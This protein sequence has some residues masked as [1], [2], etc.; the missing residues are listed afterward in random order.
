MWFI[1]YK[2]QLLIQEKQGSYHI[3]LL[4]IVEQDKLPLINQF[5]L[6]Q[7]DSIHCF[8]AEINPKTSTPSGYQSLGLRQLFGLISDDL[9]TLAGR[10]IHLLYWDSTTQFCGRC[11]HTTL[12]KTDERAKE[13]PQ[14]G[15]INYPQ[16]APAVIILIEKD[17]EILLA[18]SPR[19][20]PKMYSVI[21]GFVE[22]GETLEQTVLREIREEVGIQ[23]HNI[24][25][26]GSQHWPF[27][28]SLMIAFTA[29]YLSG[30]ITI[31]HRE[32]KMPIGSQ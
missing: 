12:L 5:Y 11:G 7:Y 6:G 1:F 9:L 32:I 29:Q 24:Q 16:L 23:V 18:R 25:Y 21:A 17:N 3:P 31:D 27:P 2:N 26:F 15:L 10:A 8:G 30:Q 13:C 4:N 28:Q 19:F 14:C 22:P 20:K